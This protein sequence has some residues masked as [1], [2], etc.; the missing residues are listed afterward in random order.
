VA[1]TGGDEFLV[2]VTDTPE[3][4]AFL[5]ARRFSLEVFDNITMEVGDNEFFPVTVSLGVAGSDQVSHDDLLKTA[6]RRMYEAKEAYYQTHKR[7]R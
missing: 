1:R 3:E 5:L 4:G 6:D 2:L 7:Y